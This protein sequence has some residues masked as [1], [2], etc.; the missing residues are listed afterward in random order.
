M[1]SQSRQ[2]HLIHGMF[3]TEE[4]ATFPTVDASICGTQTSAAH[5]VR[6]SPIRSMSL[7]VRAGDGLIRIYRSRGWDWDGGRCR[8]RSRLWS[9]SG[10]VGA[11]FVIRIEDVELLQ[12]LVE[13][14]ERLKL[15]RLHHLRFEPC[16]D[17]VLLHGLEMFVCVVEMAIQLQQCDLWLCSATRQVLS[18]RRPTMSSSQM[19]QTRRA[20]AGTTALS[21][22][23]CCATAAAISLSSLDDFD[24]ET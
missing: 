14:R 23:A 22:F 21:S 2:P 19:G 15:L 7:P 5:W 8:S 11:L 12:F 3:V 20:G 6:T 10:R 4:F 24:V 13:D 1:L 17:F 18:A 9:R 16:L